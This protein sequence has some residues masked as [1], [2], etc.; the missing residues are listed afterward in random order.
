MSEY[1]E[2]QSINLYPIVPTNREILPKLV[3]FHLTAK[4][5]QTNTIAI[6]AERAH[7]VGCG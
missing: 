4:P 5:I 3:A 1:D 6:R 7:L 2:P